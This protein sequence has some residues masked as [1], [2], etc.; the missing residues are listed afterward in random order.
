MTRLTA[1]YRLQLNESFTFDDARR[2]VPYLAQLGVSHLY[3]SPV[4]AARPG[5]THGYDVADPRIANPALGGDDGF[6]ALA[7]DAHAHGLGILVDIVPNHMG[8]GASN[9]FWMDVLRWGTASL[10]ARVF[11]IDWYMPGREGLLLLPVLGDELDA[12]I[13]RHEIAVAWRDGELR[14]TYYEHEWPLDPRTVHRVFAFEHT[15]ALS[16]D[17]AST[18]LR[19]RDMLFAERGATLSVGDAN[20]AV[21]ELRE[22]VERSRE[23][24]EHVEWL[25]RAF[26]E[27]DAGEYRLRALLDLQSWRLG[28]WRRAARELNYRRFFDVGELAAV[29]VEDASVFEVTHGWILDRIADRTIDGVRIDHVDGLRDPDAYLARLRQ[30]ID[31]R[32]PGEAL[33]IFVEKILSPGESLPTRWATDGTTGYEFAS[34][35]DA[36]FVDPNGVREI[37][38]AYRRLLRVRDAVRFHDVAAR[39]KELVLRRAFDADIRRLVRLLAPAGRAVAPRLPNAMLHEAVL[40]LAIALPVYRTYVRAVDESGRL[41]ASADDFRWIGDALNAARGGAADRFALQFVADVLRGEWPAADADVPSRAGIAAREFALRFQQTSGAATAKGIEDTA[42]YRWYPLASLGEVGSDPARPLDDA[43]S[44]LHAANAQRRARWPR[45]MLATET[46]DTKRSA[47]VRARIDALSDIAPEWNAL[48]ARWRRSHARL[49]RVTGRRA[50]PDANVEYLGYQMLVGIWPAARDVD[51]DERASLCERVTAYLCK[52]AREAKAQ[53]SWTDADSAYEAAIGAFVTALVEHHDCARFREALAGI[54]ERVARAA[55]WT[56]LTRAALHVASPGTP[57]VYQGGELTS[58]ALVDPDNRRPVDFE[59]RASALGAIDSGAA[60]SGDALR[61]RVLATLLRLRRAPDSPLVDGTYAPIAVHGSRAEHAVAFARVTGARG[62]VVLGAT[63]TLGMH[64]NGDA[65]LGAV[66][67]D[68]RITLPRGVPSSPL[69]DVLVGTEHAPDSDRSL[70][71]A[72][73]FRDLPVACLR[74]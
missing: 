36:A 41:E 55:R 70:P 37:E 2:L 45:A 20:R 62:V 69:H 23:V 11:D 57:D 14:A 44:A 71:L 66:W 21:V 12:I 27:G 16:H 10:Y 7:A 60:T 74:W 53:T 29:R 22:A 15:R 48:V 40:Q 42:L 50:A 64:A 5:S 30:A 13:A 28:H 8:I 54:V 58:L 73:L 68:T 47:D 52:A 26:T 4:V 6:R 67:G 19:I 34:A 65:P 59:A 46:H 18:V 17:A 1:T 24:A 43:V 31:A 56:G 32:R 39:G 49:R 38:R 63:R 3:L 25:A 35:L 33:P 51:D 72:A 9:P 61:L